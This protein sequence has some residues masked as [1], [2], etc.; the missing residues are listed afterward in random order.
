MSLVRT[1]AAGSILVLTLSACG[2]TAPT[3]SPAPAPA[4]QASQ[5]PA[6]PAPGSPA[7]G[8]STPSEAARPKPSTPVTDLA[9]T[10]TV[11]G[12]DFRPATAQESGQGSE[13]NRMLSQ[14]KVQPAECE[15]V[16]KYALGADQSRFG[17][18]LA[19]AGGATYV[20]GV[21]DTN[22]SLKQMKADF[23]ACPRFTLDLGGIKG[24]SELKVSDLA[25]TGASDAFAVEGRTTVAGQQATNYAN[26][27][28]VRGL[29]VSTTGVGQSIDQAKVSEAFRA[30]VEKVAAA[31]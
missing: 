18:S 4:P 19:Q 15:K 3:Q 28:L 26:N 6:S 22:A 30:Q 31:K 12:L 5:G 21:G 11:A 24:E 20:A 29:L 17:R 10:G 25:G 13:L 1:A 23:Q 2:G 9:V 27:G 16:A 14:M 8:P 7:G